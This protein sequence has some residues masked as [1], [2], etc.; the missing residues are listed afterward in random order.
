MLLSLKFKEN[1][2]SI[3]IS[4]LPFCCVSLL[5]LHFGVLVLAF[6]LHFFAI[7]EVL[8]RKNSLK[9]NFYVKKNNKIRYYIKDLLSFPKD[10]KYGTF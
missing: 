7:F 2:C 9:N 5:K 6:L 3:S 1:P 8:N 10:M 4:C